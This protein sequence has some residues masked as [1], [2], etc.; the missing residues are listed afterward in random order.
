MAGLTDRLKKIGLRKVDRE[1]YIV[2]LAENDIHVEN[3][4]KNESPERAYAEIVVPLFYRSFEDVLRDVYH[5]R[6]DIKRAWYKDGKWV[7]LDIDDL[8]RK[9]EHYAGECK[10]QGFLKIRFKGGHNYKHEIVFMKRTFG[11]NHVVVT[12]RIEIPH[13]KR[14]LYG[15]DGKFEDFKVVKCTYIPNDGDLQMV[16]YVEVPMANK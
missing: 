15:L 12:A 1:T 16:R 3:E 2:L 14:G 8:E 13:G 11:S 6:E 5:A 4:E 9:I 10:K 7:V